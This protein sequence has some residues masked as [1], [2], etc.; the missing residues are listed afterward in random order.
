MSLN[1]VVNNFTAAN[2]KEY[3]Y[4]IFVESKL[5][6]E[7]LTRDVRKVKS[8]E[9]DQQQRCHDDE[10]CV[11][12]IITHMNERTSSVNIPSYCLYMESRFE[13]WATINIVKVAV[14]NTYVLS[15]CNM[16]ISL[17]FFLSQQRTLQHML[18]KRLSQQR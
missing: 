17:L 10:S 9:H 8:C 14:L 15:R 18:F 2:I 1:V 6:P 7:S 12:P 11:Q 13:P 16:A 5:L 3:Y 4:D